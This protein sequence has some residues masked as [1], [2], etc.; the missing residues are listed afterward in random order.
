MKKII[1][2]IEN[3]EY[4]RKYLEQIDKKGNKTINTDNYIFNN[5][6]LERVT[7]TSE[8]IVD[9]T[10]ELTEVSNEITESFKNTFISRGREATIEQIY[11]ANETAKVVLGKSQDSHIIVD[12]APCG[13]G[14]ST[15][16]LEL[17]K[18]FTK[19]YEKEILTTGVIIVGDRLE[20][21]KQLQ[22]DL[23]EY[24]R[25]TFL[26]EG[27]NEEVCKDKS[28]K[29]AENKMCRKCTYTNCKVKIQGYEQSKYPILLITNARLQ[30][31][32]EMIGSQYKKWDGGERK[33]LL[34]D[35]RP[36]IL[37]NVL[38]SKELLNKIDTAI[39]NVDYE[40][41]SEKTQL[42]NY[43][44]EIINLVESKMIPL[45]ENYKRFIISNTCNI[46]VCLDNES[47]KKLWD[48]YMKKDFD[49][50][51]THIHTVLTRGGFYVC[52][53]NKEFIATIGCRNLR[54]DYKDFEKVVIFDGSALYDPQYISMYDYNEE[55]GEDNSD[56]RFLYIS[57]GRTYENLNITANLAHKISKTEFKNKSKYL[58]KAISE[59]IKSKVNIGFHANNYVVTYKE[60]AG[61]LGQLLDN[62]TL[63]HRIPKNAD[64]KAYYFG[65]TKGS[66]EMESCTRMFQIGWDT[67][68]DYLVAIMWL[69][70]KG[71]WDKFLELCLDKEKAILYSEML[72]KMDRH[73]DTF[74]QK[75]Y[76]SG[77]KNYCF[78]LV[79]IDQFQ[80]LDTVSK[81]YQEIHRT[82]LRDYN[83]K[84]DIDIYVFQASKYLI[85]EMIKNLLPKC[86]FKT[87][88]D[89]LSEF[90]RA[91]DES[92]TKADGTKTVAQKFLDWNTNDWNGEKVNISEIKSK[93]EMN[94]EEWKNV[95][96]NK[97]VKEILSEC[98][99]IREGKEYYLARI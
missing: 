15:I 8:D 19:L 32:G 72:Q 1:T 81:F 42:S 47:F 74:R 89:T 43:W 60:Q 3:I 21:L 86:N 57:N 65:N 40:N 9:I 87:N 66:N 62:S 46:G 58:V 2:L 88:K 54:N 67:L 59:Y 51:L 55:T 79:E 83:Y 98:T 94:N 13:F 61:Q 70:C 17:M 68:P 77:N 75:T 26:L 69:S 12:P 5:L 63:K 34:I 41:M 4:G 36:Q 53:S 11:F 22:T 93:C 24:S 52:E 73:E 37:D 6:S 7:Y 50:E 35:E 91:K 49:R 18:Y 33:I 31:F 99:T 39:S 78:G 82:K 28:I 64:G 95:K 90:Q 48:K 16:K 30:Q 84:N 38:V 85:F 92:F 14:K 44:K 76:S 27:W 29:I 80:Y 56:L 45:R 20:D 25:Y 96:K 71:S 97:S 10:D 23:G